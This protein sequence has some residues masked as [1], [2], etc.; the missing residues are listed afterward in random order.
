MIQS[1]SNWDPRAPPATTNSC[2]APSS[3]AASE[4]PSMVASNGTTTRHRRHA[5]RATCP[6]PSRCRKTTP[7]RAV[8]TVATATMC[9]GLLLVLLLPGASA[10]FAASWTAPIP[11]S[12]AWTKSSSMASTP[13][14]RGDEPASFTAWRRRPLSPP[15]FLRMSPNEVAHD[16][17]ST[18][19]TTTTTTTTAKP[20]DEE[21]VNDGPMAWMEP[22][23]QRMGI[24]EGK[25]IAYGP[26]AVDVDEANRPPPQV[27][28]LLRNE[29]AQNLV[30]INV[31]ERQRRDVAGTL[32][33]YAT[34]S[35]ATWAAVL[36]DDGGWGGHVL[37]FVTVIPLFLA[38]GYKRSAKTGT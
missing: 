5:A 36:A 25:A 38:V 31:Q 30:N 34:V 2:S 16:D 8:V 32:A 14:A 37:R 4:M 11:S 6:S 18:T 12:M 15:K 17:A 26:I 10:A 13:R 29:A 9:A 7:H 20:Q 33:W 19:T 35:Y 22:Y 24:E 28:E 23:L 1:S 21:F 3:I 27:A